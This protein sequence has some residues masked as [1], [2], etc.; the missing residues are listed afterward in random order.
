MNTKHTL[1]QMMELKLFGMA[2]SYETQLNQPAHHQPDGHTLIAMLTEAEAHSRV[3]QRTNLYLRLAKLRYLIQPE[4][5]NCSAERNLTR[6]QLRF[7][8]E[9][10]FIENAE[11]VLITGATGCGKSYLACALGNRACTLGYK[12]IY[13]SM[14]RFIEILATARIDGS[15]IK[16][17]NMIAK[18]PLLILDDFGLQP[19]DH[20]TRI[21]LLQILE[22][23][24][25]KSSMIITSQLPV[26]EWYEHIGDPTL[27]DA[28]MDRMTAAMH[29]VEL[30]G[31]SLRKQKNV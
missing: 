6:E 23:R 12:T 5:I 13:Y 16:L 18:T 3:H 10:A 28:I 17:L 14:N 24:Y 27:A 7:L 19:I 20:N 25:K 11:N 8:S 31:E 2:K 9:V 15:Y 22:D 1:E 21:T 26:K 4:Q 30:K 29:K